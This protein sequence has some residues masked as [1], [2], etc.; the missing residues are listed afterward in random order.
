ML[1]R[2]SSLR[3]TSLY[4]IDLPLLGALPGLEKKRTAASS[5]M[6]S[7]SR[8]LLGV[9]SLDAALLLVARLTSAYHFVF[10]TPLLSSA[11]VSV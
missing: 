8:W 1:L 6:G 2:L 7:I 9:D 3:N 10:L 11:A 4:A 5:R